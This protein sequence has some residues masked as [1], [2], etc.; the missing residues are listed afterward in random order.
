MQSDAPDAS[1]QQ[2]L[3]SG[4]S[5]L[6]SWYPDP[7]DAGRMRYWDGSQWT[8]RTRSRDS[9][10]SARPYRP[11]AGPARV[12]QVLL[13]VYTLIVLAAVASD[14]LEVNLLNRLLHDPAGVLPSEVSAS[15]VRQVL[16]LLQIGATLAIAVAF[17]VWF[18]RAFANLP[19]LGMAPLPFGAGW[20]IGGWLVPIL[21]LFRPKNI[22]DDIWRGSDP[23]RPSRLD[24]FWHDGPVPALVHAW[25]ALYLVSS[26]VGFVVAALIDNTTSRTVESVRTG[27]LATLAS[28]VLELVLALVCLELVRRVTRRQQA[29]AARL[30]ITPPG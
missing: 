29:R 13:A 18:H 19:A 30:A 10:P 17:V 15:D 22:M 21:N 1:S 11:L 3:G 23:D 25:W 2:G 24:G 7:E 9:M 14:W 8:D 6:A 28:D 20:A 16:S 27:W 5:P 26:L 12:V 4:R